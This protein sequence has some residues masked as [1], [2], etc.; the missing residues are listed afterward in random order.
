MAIISGIWTTWQRYTFILAQRD[1][2]LAEDI[3][4]ERHWLYLDEPLGNRVT[5]WAFR[6]RENPLCKGW[7]RSL[8]Q[9]FSAATP[10][11]AAAS[12]MCQNTFFF[13]GQESWPCFLAWFQHKQLNFCHLN[14][15]CSSC[16]H[17][18]ICCFLPRSV[19][20]HL[21]QLWGGARVNSGVGCPTAAR[22]ASLT[23]KTLQ[24]LCWKQLRPSLLV[25]PPSSPSSWRK[26]SSFLLLKMTKYWRAT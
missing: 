1:K 23:C 3:S 22:E 20:E 10:S 4:E 26:S 2:I 17:T 7:D 15:P 24:L 19:A 9:K 5:G 18:V 6:Y 14:N 13:K 8:L 25:V 16:W 11:A 21:C 12:V